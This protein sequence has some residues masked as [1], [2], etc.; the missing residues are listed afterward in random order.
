MKELD[1]FPMGRRA[2]NEFKIDN[3]LSDIIRKLEK[4]QYIILDNDTNVNLRISLG[5]LARQT[6]ALIVAS[7]QRK[8]VLLLRKKRIREKFRNSYYSIFQWR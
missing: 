4:R 2:K 3:S 6:D 7:I 8:R 5:I 1:V